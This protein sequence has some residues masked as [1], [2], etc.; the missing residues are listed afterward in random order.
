MLSHMVDVKQVPAFQILKKKF[1]LKIKQ[2]QISSEV[3]NKDVRNKNFDF[4]K[5]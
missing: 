4:H 2:G 3:C 1:L 5:S